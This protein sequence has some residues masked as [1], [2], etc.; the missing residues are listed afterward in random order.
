MKY[1]FVSYLTV[2]FFMSLR[3]A[4]KTLSLSSD[5]VFLPAPPGAD[6]SG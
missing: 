5:G 4:C 2:Q 6:R 3:Q 1:E